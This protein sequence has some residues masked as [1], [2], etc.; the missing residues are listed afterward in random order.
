MADLSD[1]ELIN[2]SGLPSGTA[3]GSNLLA[4]DDGS[5][6]TKITINQAVAASQ[7]M[8]QVNNKIGDTTLPTTA[9]TLTGAIAEHEADLTA[10]N[11]NLTTTNGYI[12]NIRYAQYAVLGGSSKN[13]T[14][15]TWAVYLV[16]TFQ[17]FHVVFTG[18]SSYT[19]VISTVKNNSSLP[20]TGASNA[21]IVLQNTTG[22]TYQFSVIRIL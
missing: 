14:L 12:G 1:F 22:S 3:A 13:V 17:G 4:Q 8:Q 9:Q 7:A 21:E 15:A 6:I 10:L 20:V 2:I 19:P 16:S 11:G 18:N 5:N